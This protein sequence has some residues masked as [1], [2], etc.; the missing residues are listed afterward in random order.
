MIA[1]FDTNVTLSTKLL[2]ANLVSNTLPNSTILSSTGIRVT[3]F[4]SSF[5]FTPK[6]FPDLQPLNRLHTNYFVHEVQQVVRK[7]SILYA[8]DAAIDRD[9]QS[10]SNN[11]D[12]LLRPGD[13]V[14]RTTPARGISSTISDGPYMLLNQVGSNIWRMFKLEDG[15]ISTIIECPTA[16]LQRYVCVPEMRGFPGAPPVPNSEPSEFKKNDMFV[17]KIETT[18]ESIALYQVEIN[19]VDSKKILARNWRP[20]SLMQFFCTDK[21]SIIPWSNV[22]LGKLKLQQRMISQ[23]TQQAIFTLLGGRL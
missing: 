18:S 20:N 4:E 10:S 22:I 3:P 21:T 17:A 5:G 23:P 7:A 2:I 15:L 14:I 9:Y 13:M 1:N 16:L 19:D 11:P 12:I 6:T 8:Q